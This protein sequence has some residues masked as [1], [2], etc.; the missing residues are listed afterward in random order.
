MLDQIIEDNQLATVGDRRWGTLP[1]VGQ[2]ALAGDLGLDWPDEADS[3]HLVFVA[4]D[5]P[6][7][8]ANPM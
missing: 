6:T 7:A 3:R 5:V 4:G 8:E 1:G 2:D